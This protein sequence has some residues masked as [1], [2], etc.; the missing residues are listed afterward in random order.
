MLKHK[1]IQ[2]IT[3][4]RRYFIALKARQKLKFA[5]TDNPILRAGWGGK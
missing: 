1:G 2:P 4:E 5:R 3:T